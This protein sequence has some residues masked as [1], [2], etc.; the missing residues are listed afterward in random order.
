MRQ[1]KIVI[2][3]LV[4]CNLPDATEAYAEL[5]A[6]KYLF[7]SSGKC[8]IIVF[9]LPELM[10]TVSLSNRYGDVEKMSIKCFLTHYSAV[11]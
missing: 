5:I 1:K 2:S 11:L 6:L 4:V 8:F 3:S 10:E 7:S 9:C